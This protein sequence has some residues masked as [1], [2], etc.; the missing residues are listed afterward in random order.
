MTEVHKVTTGIYHSV[1]ILTQRLVVSL[2]RK[3]LTVQ[4]QGVAVCPA[5]S[6]V[7]VL[8]GPSNMAWDASS[9]V[10]VTL[11]YLESFYDLSDVKV[12]G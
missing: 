3:F 4:Q 2:F 1:L 6:W 11:P 5:Q 10:L 7:L 12:C 9:V 8:S